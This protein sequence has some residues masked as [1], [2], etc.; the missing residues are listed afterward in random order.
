MAAIPEGTMSANSPIVLALDFDGVVCDGLREYF[1]TAWR[2]YCQI[3]K[4][5]DETPSEELAPQFYRL[6]PVVES[7][8]EMPILIRSLV[9]GTPEDEILQNW[10]AIAAQFITDD[11]LSAANVSAIVDE[12]RDQ[13]IATDLES[14]LAEHRF[15]PGVVDRLREE[16]AST[17][18]VIISTK[19]G[20]F[21]KQLLQ[22]QGIVLSDRQVYGKEVKRP[23][24]Q[25]LKELTLEYGTTSIWFIEDRLKTLETVKKQ[26]GLENVTLFLADWGY[27]TIADRQLASEDDRIH[28]LSLEQFTQ[29]SAN[30]GVEK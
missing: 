25:I 1:Q 7:G 20:R 10:A 9:L 28:R 11:E 13:W 27:N 14:W 4:P 22:Q 18:C 24:Y 29:D 19:E 16:L 15:Y 23:K 26:A 3:W 2:A 6:R 30:W 17:Q 5:D 12:I 21:I 8:W